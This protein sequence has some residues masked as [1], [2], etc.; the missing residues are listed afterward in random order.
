MHPVFAIYKGTNEFYDP[1]I[2]KE[3]QNIKTGAT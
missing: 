1:E 3:K 2:I